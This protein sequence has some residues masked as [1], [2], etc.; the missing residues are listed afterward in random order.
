MA[1]ILSETTADA[2]LAEPA[3]RDFLYLVTGSVAAVGT[4]AVIWPFIDQMNPDA[5]T[6]AAAGP[7]DIDVS[8]IQEGQR[9][10]TL[11]AARPVFIVRRPQSALE[12]LRDPKLISQLRDP[13][14]DN[15]QQPD[16]SR[17]WHRSIKPEFL[18]LV[19]IC[20]HLGC[21]PLYDP[22]PDPTNPAPDWLGGFFCPCHGSKYDL[23]GRVFQGV[24]APFN[25]PV[26]PYH[27]PNDKTLRVGENPPGESYDF[28]S[29]LAV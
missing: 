23:A 16:Y 17:N 24:P 26:P 11:W 14:S 27:F 18:V 22:K 2:T 3:R 8:Q 20:T 6:I 1:H 21:V 4:A 28:N 29:I 12:E 13:N 10:V 7:V 5:A 19:G 9:I 15:W 25:L